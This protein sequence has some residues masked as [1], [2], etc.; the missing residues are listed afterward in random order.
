MQFNRRRFVRNALLGSATSLGF[1]LIS[2]PRAAAE[3]PAGELPRRIIHVVSDG[4]SLGTLS[5][6]DHF[7]LLTRKRHLTWIELSRLS[8]T[9]K[10]WMDM[11]SLN[12]LVTDSAAASSS[13]GCGSRVTNG[14]LNWLPDGRNLRPL[15][16]LFPERDWKRGLVTTT[17]IT[18]AT[19]AGFASSV[20]TRDNAQLIAEQYCHRQIEVLLGGGRKFFEGDKRADERDLIKRFQTKGYHYARNRTELLAH[21]G[22]SNLLGLFSD[23]HLP[24]NIDRKNSTKLRDTVPTLAEMTEA[25]LK[26]LHRESRFILQVEGGKVD[27]ACHNC[28]IACAVHEQVSLDEAI[29]VL[30]NYQKRVPE[31]LIVIT[32]DHGNGNPGLCAYGSAEGSSAFGN[33]KNARKSFPEILKDVEKIEDP[34]KIRT[35]IRDATDYRASSEKIKAFTSLLTK[36]SKPLNDQL[37]S[38]TGHLGQLL[39]N[40]YGIGWASGS[41]TSDFVPLL[42]VGPG[43]ELFRGFVENTDVFHHYL[44]LARIDYQNPALPLRAEFSPEALRVENIASY[45]LPTDLHHA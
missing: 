13:W 7:S 33:L 26:R 6:A 34:E 40:F 39:A 27:H 25:A 17:E 36:K 4:M 16:E 15:Y 18:H 1:P 19:P 21:S 28:D 30:V 8:T 45:R 42:A 43:S 9:V 31:T 3:A 10:T 2:Q 12:S 37:N 35:I 32:A 41:H 23:S 20:S 44:S 24:Y 11:R 29:E 38:N 22:D 14:A 5:C